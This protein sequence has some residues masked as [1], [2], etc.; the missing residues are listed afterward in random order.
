MEKI[1]CLTD[2]T[3]ISK[4]AMDFAQ[5]LAGSLKAQLVLF[6]SVPQE[7]PVRHMPVGGVPFMEPIP[8][9]EEQKNRETQVRLA[10]EKLFS[11]SQNVPGVQSELRVGPITTTL[12]QAAAETEADFIVL[13]HEGLEISFPGS[14]TSKIIGTVPCPVFVLPPQATFQPLRKIVYATDLKADSFTDVSFVTQLAAAFNA[15]IQF[16]H[17]LMDD[18]LDTRAQAEAEL[19]LICR[20]SMYPHMSYFLETAKKVELGIQHFCTAQHADLLV[21]GSRN[22]NFWQL[23][24][25]SKTQTISSHPLLP[26]LV[27]PYKK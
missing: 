11:F 12:P 21:M 9:V 22:N 6:H 3:P 1:L 13:A 18:A 10:K 14:V 20:R 16:L 17:I 19:R 15:E 25:Q 5:Q 8:D 23:F 27:L 26:L 7:E 2:F 4:V 24:F